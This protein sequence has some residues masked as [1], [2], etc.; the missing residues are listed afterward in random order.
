[1]KPLGGAVVNAL[2]TPMRI[3]GGEDVL[4]RR[5]YCYS[6]WH[7]SCARSLVKNYNCGLVSFRRSSRAEDG[8]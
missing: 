1:M 7:V 2:Q 5:S 6:E 3:Y 4:W 8:N